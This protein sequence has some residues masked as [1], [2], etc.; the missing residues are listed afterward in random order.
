MSAGGPAVFDAVAISLDGKNLVEAS[1]GTG[2]TYAITTLFVRLLLESKL[3]PSEILVVTFTEAATAELRDR[4]RGRIVEAEA[5]FC[6]ALAGQTPKDDALA[7]LAKRRGSA[8]DGDLKRL[9]RAIENI[10]EAPISTIHGF[11]QRV[12]HDNAFGTRVPFGAELIPDLS[13]LYDDVLYDLWLG[14]VAHGSPG[15]ARQAAA[16]GVD[17]PRLR[18]LLE[19]S[20]RNPRVAVVPPA[21]ASPS[22]E[23]LERALGEVRRELARFDGFAYVDEHCLKDKFD[24]GAAL[25]GLLG[26]LRACL[27][28]G[29]AD[30]LHFPAGAEKLFPSHVA[31]S[32][33]K[34]FASD[35]GAGH[36][37][38][39][40]FERLVRLSWLRV[41]SLEHQVLSEAPK[42]LFRRKT[43]RGVL[44]FE[45]LLLRVADALEG[46]GG[47]KLAEVLR[48]RF[49]AVLIDEFQ[50][51]DPVQFEI[52]ERVF[53]G[54]SHP[55]FLIGDPKQAIYAFRGADVFAYL[56]AAQSARRFS[57][58]TSYRSDPGHV[59][60]VNQLF[61][62][63][64]AFL[65]PAIGYRAVAPAPEAANA[66]HAP[67]ASGAASVELLFATRAD[68][69]RPVNKPVARRAAARLVAADLVRLL[70][71]GAT[72]T[73][74]GASLPVSA[75][76]VAVLT[77]TNAQ[78]F[79][80]Q[81][82]LRARGIVSVVISDTSVFES[83]EA[84]DLQAVLG[85]VLDPMSRFDLRRAVATSLL[86]VTGDEIAAR[87]SDPEWWQT[88]V[89]RFR[90][91]HG[92]W[93]ERGF[94]RMFRALLTDTPAAANLLALAGGER[95][96]TNVLHL[97]ELLHRAAT[98]QHLGPAALLAWLSEQRAGAATA[99]ERAEIR[100]ESDEAAVKILTVHKAKGLEFPVVYCPFLW[101][102]GGGRR[103]NGPFRF[104][105][106]SGSAALDIDVDSKARAG[107][108]EQ[109]R[110]ESFAEEM[111]VAYV[112]LTRAKHRTTVVWGGFNQLGDSAAAFLLH[113]PGA[114]TPPEVPDATRLSQAT[115]RD[116]EADLGRLA[117]RS[118]GALALRLV[119]LNDD[120]APL[121]SAAKTSRA[122]QAR[123]IAHRV[124]SWQ[125]T[126]SFSNL[127]QRELGWQLDQEEGRD[128]DEEGDAG[129][130]AEVAPEP[131]A[132]AER[133]RITLDGFPR[134]RRTGDLIH[135]VFEHLDFATATDDEIAAVVQAKLDGFGFTPSF[136][137]EEASVRRAQLVRAVRETL[138]APLFAGGPRLRDIGAR[139]KF[140]ELEFRMPVGEGDA[141]LTRRRLA[142]VFRAHPS[143]RPS[144]A[145]P[146]AYAD[147]VERLGFRELRGFLKGYVDLVF[148][149]AG[150][151]YVVDY[152]TNHLGDF[153]DDYGVSAMR[154]ELDESHYFLQYHLYALALDRYL[155]HWQ[156]GYQYEKH[157]GGVCYLFIKGMHPSAPA[158][159][160]VFFEKPPV[161]RMRALAAALHGTTPGTEARAGG[162]A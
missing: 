5:A 160:G 95:R 76:D 126:S 26:A 22:P 58:G 79:M 14:R 109:S 113:P 66:F 15:L 36:P 97:S 49:K 72:M 141:G 110:W 136:T 120:A 157:F 32:L 4:V 65:I 149:H 81:D 150:L 52:F 125:R 114:L 86:G 154:R 24:G 12:L 34:K 83:E 51:T 57:M 131:V 144:G 37:F 161:A 105:D 119:P 41:L 135:D 75:G 29:D 107:N 121:V 132:P 118:K 96:L 9:R 44:G 82:A 78:C 67:H 69:E 151:W 19:E 10:D 63:P 48:Q 130:V 104:H 128:R 90:K 7:E 148:E 93:L 11:C 46:E 62:P 1:A 31:L 28:G 60:V 92:L 129:G 13:D 137:P 59:A 84:A 30:D 152:K 100:L 33:Q 50:D 35:F 39:T 139:N 122:F 55:L 77:R 20:R 8:L 71:G 158:G 102:A 111:R 108:F 87:E 133:V 61:E 16:L 89:T 47:A 159:N 145:L 162:G 140:A 116:L 134:G 45:D 6:S 3:D 25:T 153:R 99:L 156:R 147:R 85:A 112:A 143:D 115:D 74:K 146:A 103:A 101:D 64:G 73:R 80:V 17:M 38:F 56:A 2:K 117:A 138:E 88:W 123:P 127:I 21:A 23:A 91:W 27:A 68:D 142:E 18:Q 106:S 43:Q 155:A 54:G 70:S 42:E 98:E 124:H 53:G 94:V 40:A